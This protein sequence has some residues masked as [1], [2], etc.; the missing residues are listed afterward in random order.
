[1][2][3][4]TNERMAGP[5]AGRALLVAAVLMAGLACGRGAA[6]EMSNRYV[7]IAEIE[8]DPAQ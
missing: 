1:M 7:Q 2:S 4:T 8:I 6:Q 5:A 3:N